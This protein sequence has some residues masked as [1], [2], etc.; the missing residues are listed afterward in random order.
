MTVLRI[1]RSFLCHIVCVPLPQSTSTHLHACLHA[2]ASSDVCV[3][4]AFRLDS[5]QLI[6]SFS[7]RF[8][9]QSIYYK[10]ASA[11]IETNLKCVWWNLWTKFKAEYEW[12]LCLFYPYLSS[13]TMKMHVSSWSA[14]RSGHFIGLTI[15][16]AEICHA[17]M[18]SIAS[19]LFVDLFTIAHCVHYSKILQLH[20]RFTVSMSCWAAY[21]YRSIFHWVNDQW[22]SYYLFLSNSYTFTCELSTENGIIRN[23]LKLILINL[24]SQQQLSGIAAVFAILFRKK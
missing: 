11:T 9:C 7:F 3:C 13:M 24:R 2:V 17:L 12:V 10:L 5:I 15:V 21:N 23:K 19:L 14:D 8:I 16:C 18:M 4:F 1:I 6:V 22:L 20:T